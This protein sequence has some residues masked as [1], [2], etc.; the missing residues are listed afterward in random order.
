MDCAVPAKGPSISTLQ[1]SI[2]SEDTMVGYHCGQRVAHIEETR[3]SFTKQCV[4]CKKKFHQRK[5]LKK[6]A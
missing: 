6:A 2:F 4:V 3:E 1:S 5:R